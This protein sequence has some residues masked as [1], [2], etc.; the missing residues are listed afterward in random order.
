[1]RK[2]HY[3]AVLGALAITATAC[4]SGST[5]TRRHVVPSGDDSGY[6]R[7]LHTAGG[8]ATL[9]RR[10]T[11]IVSL[12]ATATEMLYAI[13]A[14]TQVIAVDKYSTYPST[15]PRTNLSSL[16]PNVEAI[17]RYQPD[18]VITDSNSN[19]LA[20]SL[21]T[22]HVPLLIEPP[23]P[24]FHA[25][26]QQINQLGVATD[27]AAAARRTITSMRTRIENIIASTPRPPSPLR[28]YH[29]L[30]P[31]YYSATSD[32]FIGQIYQLLGLHN[33]ADKP[34]AAA[35]S[36]YPQLSGE[37]VLTADPQI[38][39][40]A[41]TTCCH[42]DVRT[43]ANRPGWSNIDAVKHRLVLAVPDAL[44]SEWGPRI[45]GFVAR[46]ATLA[47]QAETIYASRQVN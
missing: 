39:V 26:Y 4:A 8:Q 44:A 15:A 32:T 13:G 12:S 10:P 1:M 36:S 38:V 7:T 30:D 3:I 20:R 19:N 42:Q 22:L 16:Q 47:R 24:T 14:G 35:H 28:V 46:V 33:I 40:L 27:H 43:V 31:T 37:Y 23:A 25:A 2:H 18:L 41:D 29:E 11:R 5:T 45:V 34:G 21:R 17:A 9:A 6:P